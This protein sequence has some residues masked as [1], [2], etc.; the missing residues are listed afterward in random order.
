MCSTY[1][2]PGADEMFSDLFAEAIPVS[3][4]NILYPV[5]K[6]LFHL[7]DIYGRMAQHQRG[8]MLA[9]FSPGFCLFQLPALL[10]NHSAVRGI[11][12]FI[13]MIWHY[14]GTLC[15][16]IIRNIPITSFLDSLYNYP[17][18]FYILLSYA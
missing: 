7:Q 3:G 18:N 6:I 13:L 10:C 2:L 1:P 9:Q 17:E 14:I 12:Y 11:L 8:N 5:I 15:A 16:V 4:I